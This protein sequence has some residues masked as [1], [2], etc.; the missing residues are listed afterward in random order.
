MTEGNPDVNYTLGWIELKYAKE[1]PKRG[2]PL[3]IPHFTQEQRGWLIRRCAAGGRAYLLLKVGDDEW[4]L[5]KGSIAAQVVGHYVRD[6][7]YQA[8]MARWTRKP[9]KEEIQTWLR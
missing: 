7:L 5:F 9:K 1:W 8:C 2:G 3:R 4:L 6:E